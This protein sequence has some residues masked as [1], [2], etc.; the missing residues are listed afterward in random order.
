[1][2]LSFVRKVKLLRKRNLITETVPFQNNEYKVLW[3]CGQ[4]SREI[5]ALR[6]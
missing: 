5:E 2:K 1:M 6:T 3:G 4:S